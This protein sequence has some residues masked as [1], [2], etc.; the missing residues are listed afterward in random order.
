MSD[1]Y[2]RSKPLLVVFALSLT[3]TQFA[4]LE[5]PASVNNKITVLKLVF[6]P[7]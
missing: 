7:L 6:P 3:A 4:V 2:N 5:Q 1:A